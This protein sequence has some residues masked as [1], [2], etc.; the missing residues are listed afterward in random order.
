MA[1]ELIKA[2]IPPD[3]EDFYLSIA[4]GASKYAV[5]NLLEEGLPVRLTVQ[6]SFD[7]IVRV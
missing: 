7:Y 6:L 3:D 4:I 1:L 5:R 2:F